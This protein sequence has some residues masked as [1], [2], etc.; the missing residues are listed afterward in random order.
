MRSRPLSTLPLALALLAATAPALAQETPLESLEVSLWPEYDRPSM[1]V[2]YRVTLAPEIAL[3]A[4]VQLRIPAAAGEPSAVAVQQSSGTLVNAPY[5]RHVEGGWSRIVITTTEPRLQVEYYDPSLLRDGARRSYTYTWPGDHAVRSFVVE[6]QEPVDTTDLRTVPPSS[7]GAP[8]PE[9]LT[10]HFLTLP[11]AAR[12]RETVV[13]IDYVRDGDALSIDSLPP[14]Q[15]LPGE[16]LGNPVP[17]G[18]GAGVGGDPRWRALGGGLLAASLAALAAYWLL[19]RRE[20]GRRA[21]SGPGK[22]A[23]GRKG[24]GRF[25]TRCGAAA[26]NEADRFCHACGHRRR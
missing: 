5:E 2:L 26:L 16:I 24:P 10:H 23:G 17:R 3:P 7:P 6:V 9:G 4:T 22:R 21:E 19:F 8:G 1:L 14:Q 12:G 18:A 13:Q 11:P 25:C 15:R 20:G